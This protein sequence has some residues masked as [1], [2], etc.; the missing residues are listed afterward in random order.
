M[1]AV[2]NRMM[3]GACD[4]APLTVGLRE[5]AGALCEHVDVYCVEHLCIGIAA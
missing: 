4:G 2:M 5:A 3:C 1:A